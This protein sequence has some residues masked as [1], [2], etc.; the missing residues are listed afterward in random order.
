[1]AVERLPRHAHDPEQR[2]HG[3]PRNAGHR[4]DHIHG[5]SRIR[6]EVIHRIVSNLNV[7]DPSAGHDFYVDFLGLK[8]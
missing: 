1:V 8:K 6:H 3:S 5:Q 4:P 7:G 2:W